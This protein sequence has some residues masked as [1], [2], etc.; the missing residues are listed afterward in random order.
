MN[1]FKIEFDPDFLGFAWDCVKD[2]AMDVILFAIVF[3]NLVTA[4]H[5]F[6]VGGVLFSILGAIMFAV[7][8]VFWFAWLYREPTV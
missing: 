2:V 1:L 6:Y 7:S 5:L 4:L 3:T 8:V